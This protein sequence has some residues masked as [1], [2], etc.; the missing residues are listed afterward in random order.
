MFRGALFEKQNST[1]SRDASDSA[2]LC[3]CLLYS[4]GLDLRRSVRPHP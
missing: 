2:P 4:S 3:A 1:V